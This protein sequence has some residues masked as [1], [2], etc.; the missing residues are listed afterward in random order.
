MNNNWAGAVRRELWDQAEAENGS[1]IVKSG[2]T[3]KNIDQGLRSPTLTYE[4]DVGLM[5]VT[6]R[7]LP[8]RR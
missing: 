4:D 8:D 6:E 1:K 3:K 7:S 2:I 5:E